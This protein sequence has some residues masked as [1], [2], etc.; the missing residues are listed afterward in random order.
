MERIVANPMSDD[1]GYLTKEQYSKLLDTLAKRSSR[2]KNLFLFLMLTGR[3]ISEVI[4]GTHG[5]GVRV[6]DLDFESH[7]YT[8]RILKKS[9]RKHE[10]IEQGIVRP[11]PKAE[12]KPLNSILEESLRGYI[13]SKRLQ[14]ED[15]L[16][17]ISRQRAYQLAEKIGKQAG[18]GKVGNKPFHPHHLR[19]TF[20]VYVT[21][22]SA[23]TP[24]ELVNL[25][26]ILGHSSLD[27]TLTYLKYGDNKARDLTESLSILF[28]SSVPSA[29]LVPHPDKTAS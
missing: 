17:P 12:S 11:E 22:E 29:S 15:F 9:P 13:T 3:R 8:T 5:Y 10:Q 4:R 16:F 23:M 26:K 14:P 21:R 20:A 28:K 25:Q 19:H 6:K 27:T 7:N 18:L 1:K 24:E 2:D